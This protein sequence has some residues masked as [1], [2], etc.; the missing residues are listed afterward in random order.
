MKSYFII[1]FLFL[2]FIFSQGA[3]YAGPDDPAGDIEAEREGR[4]QLNLRVTQ[5]NAQVTHF[6]SL[7]HKIGQSL[8]VAQLF[9]TH[10]Q[11]ADIDELLAES[12][13]LTE[14]A[15]TK[16]TAEAAERTTNEVK[17]KLEAEALVYQN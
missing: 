10:M 16:A 13:Q 11:E 12:R 7:S 1:G 8:E 3:D 5:L 9:L 14:E 6:A 17:A 2:S 4:E 15:I